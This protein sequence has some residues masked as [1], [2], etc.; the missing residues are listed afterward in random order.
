MQTA[1]INLDDVIS[2]ESEIYGVPIE[3]EP[4]TT[5]PDGWEE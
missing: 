4:V 2:E 5:V 1:M 3:E